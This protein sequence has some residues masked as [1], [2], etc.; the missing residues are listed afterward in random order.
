MS[1]PEIDHCLMPEPAP[2]RE[3]EIYT[4]LRDRLV[5]AHC[6]A[7]REHACCGKITIDRAH[8]TFNC[9]LCGDAR[10]LI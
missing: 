10:Q 6:E 9:P 2:S 5:R 8:I 1:H 7:K 3:A 4:K